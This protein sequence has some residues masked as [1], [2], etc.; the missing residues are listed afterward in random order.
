MAYA[1]NRVRCAVSWSY[2]GTCYS[3]VHL[4]ISFLLSYTISYDTGGKA[5]GLLQEMSSCLKLVFA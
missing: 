5:Y 2:I 1:C 3:I 4:F